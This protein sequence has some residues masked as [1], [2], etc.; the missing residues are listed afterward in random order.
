MQAPSSAPPRRRRLRLIPA[1]KLVPSGMTVLALCAGLT[2]M[3]MG[4][5]EHWRLA[6]VSILIAAILDF[7][8]GRVA[9]LL[10]GDS[11]F[12]A[13]LD[14][15]SD[16]V[17]FGVAP[18]ML[19]YHWSLYALGGIGWVLSLGLAVCCALRLAR[20]NT[21][22]DTPEELTAG[23]RYFVGV[24]APAGAGIA[25]M[26]LMFDF[27]IEAPVFQTPVLT[28]LFV[29]LA[30][31]LMVSSI[32]TYSPKRIAVR[33]DYVV[34][35]FLCIGIFAAFLTSYLWGTLALACALYLITIPFSYRQRRAE[36]AAEKAAAAD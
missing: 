17:S 16:V 21:M 6:V 20:F 15:L 5:E 36:C 26:P 12:G 2:S 10:K 19:L 8:D 31:F 13:E 24:P 14:S 28:A 3:R 11:K 18:A 35:V 9:R 34:P 22:L 33:R 7:L 29:A 30:A 1:R 32:P 25:L 23:S 4:L 27:Q